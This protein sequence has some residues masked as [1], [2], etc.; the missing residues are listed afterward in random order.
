MLCVKADLPR[1]HHCDATE[2]HGPGHRGISG[3]RSPLGIVQSL[4]QDAASDYC[5]VKPT[6]YVGSHLQAPEARQCHAKLFALSQHQRQDLL[7]GSFQL[8]RVRAVQVLP[9]KQRLQTGPL[10]EQLGGG[11][12]V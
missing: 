8:V 12:D 4:F 5:P 10:L 11:L 1:L 6:V 9:Y 3:G 2:D 7:D